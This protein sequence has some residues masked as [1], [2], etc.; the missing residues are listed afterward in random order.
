[1]KTTIR[2]NG[3][4]AIEPE[5]SLEEYALKKWCADNKKIFDHPLSVA[6]TIVEYKD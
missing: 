2:S 1:M 6:C 5:T 3:V 4:L